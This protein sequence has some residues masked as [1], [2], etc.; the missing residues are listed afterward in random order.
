M[1]SEFLILKK[2]AAVGT[3]TFCALFGLVLVAMQI[4]L[5]RIRGES[6]AVVFV[7]EAPVTVKLDGSPQGLQDFSYDDGD[8][9]TKILL[10]FSFFSKPG[11]HVLEYAYPDSS[12]YRAVIHCGERMEAESGKEIRHDEYP[13]LKINRNNISGYPPAT[14]QKLK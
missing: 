8:Q 9:T 11:Q 6:Y 7:R 5:D 12:S 4:A 14:V 1:K 13:S 3:I 10:S 2:L